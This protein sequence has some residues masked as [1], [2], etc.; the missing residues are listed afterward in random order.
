M[1]KSVGNL[2]KCCKSQNRISKEAPQQKT[3]QNEGVNKIFENFDRVK[4]YS[5]KNITTEYSENETPEG[6]SEKD[7][8]INKCNDHYHHK[9][10]NYQNEEKN[11][12]DLIHNNRD[13]LTSNKNN[14]LIDIKKEDTKDN[15][16][17][18]FNEGDNE[19]LKNDN[20][21]EKDF[22]KIIVPEKFISEE[23]KQYMIWVII[24]FLNHS[25]PFLKF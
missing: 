9:I 8:D 20:Y 19:S 4:L 23:E 18:K 2:F 1:L 25:N 16:E 11:E 7:F 22:D 6:K 3:N 12:K 10:D 14:N 5:N 13:N 24:L 21:I 17:E 15:R